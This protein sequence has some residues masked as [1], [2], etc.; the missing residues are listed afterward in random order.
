ML[1][2]A[3]HLGQVRGSPDPVEVFVVGCIGGGTGA[4]GDGLSNGGRSGAAF[5]GAALVGAAVVDVGVGGGDIFGV[6]GT[7]ASSDGDPFVK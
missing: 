2:A 7:E 1:I 3:P 5:L 6:A 4:G